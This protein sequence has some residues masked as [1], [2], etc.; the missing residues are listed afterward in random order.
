MLR[1]GFEPGICDSKEPYEGNVMELNA[2]SLK[3]FR[4]YLMSQKIEQKTINELFRNSV[5]YHHILY[6]KDG[7][8]LLTYSVG[9][10]KHIMKALAAFSKYSGCYE[11]WQ[12]IRKQHQ[13]KWTS[14]DSF[15]GFNS[16]FKEDAS[17]SKMVGWVREA[18]E[19]YPRFANILLFDVMT[20]LRPTEAIES[21]NLLINPLSRAEYLSKDRKT[22][23][24]FRFPTVFL[25]RTKKAFITIAN[26][27]ILS[28][29]DS[30]HAEVLNYDK[31]RLTF[32]RNDQK[33]FMSYCRKIF[34]TYLRNEGV[35]SELIDVLQGRIPNSIFV[36]HYYRPDMSKFDMIR[37]KLT[38][39][40]N[41]I[42]N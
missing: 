10:R 28:L 3:G 6:E 7:S 39:L 26:A 16:I 8:D 15:S 14:V 37:E 23:E 4:E 1:P 30:R 18:I 41:L 25:R 22:L 35:E 13:L 17:F 27:D 5:K 32:L 42:V 33:F 21:F 34:A 9:K 40:H 36:R 2:K 11:T 31:I 12:M 24:H 29:T 20:G 38:G 19:K